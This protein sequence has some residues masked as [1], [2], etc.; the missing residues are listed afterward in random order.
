MRRLLCALL[1]A[2]ASPVAAQD[3]TLPAVEAPALPDTDFVIVRIDGSLNLRTGPSADAPRLR[4]MA[5]DTILR[6]IDCIAGSEEAW[7]EVETLDGA[8]E[9][10]AAARF[11]VPWRGA[12]PAALDSPTVAPTERLEIEAPG[13]FAAS[14]EGGEIFDLLLS[15]PQDQ[16]IALAVDAPDGI[17][18]AIFAPDG[19]RIETGQGA[20]A[21]SV[22]LLSGDVLLVRFV[23]TDG[24]GGMWRLD[25]TLE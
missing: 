10:W 19:R 18:T 4:R 7:C 20:A 21:F 3:T 11:L 12:D 22:V 24:Q 9:G 13:R 6:R 14:V 1:L 25:V 5:R 15:V 17:G 23:D 2:A 8:L 16:T